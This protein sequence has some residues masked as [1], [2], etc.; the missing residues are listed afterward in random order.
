MTGPTWTPADFA[1][2]EALAAPTPV[3]P[4]GA[5]RPAII[6]DARGYETIAY[7]E[8]VANPLAA[9]A[10]RAFYEHTRQALTTDETALERGEVFVERA[11]QARELQDRILAGIIVHP[12]Y[13]PKARYVNGRPPAGQLHYAAFTPEQRRLLADLFYRGA[14]ALK[15]FRAGSESDEP[16]ADHGAGLRDAPAPLPAGDGAVAGLSAVVAGRGGDGLGEP[17]PAV[18]VRAGA[19]ADGPGPVRA[20]PD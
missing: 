9:E 20:G 14:D 19:G 18:G 13:C 16:A 8:D 1:A 11:A 6:V 17:A 2:I 12:P 3:H 5:G 4:W 7:C 15:P 10:V